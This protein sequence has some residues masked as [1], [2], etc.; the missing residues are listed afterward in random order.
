MDYLV[1]G[2]G[3]IGGTVGAGL[4]RD[5]HDVVFCDADRE[6]VQAMNADGLAIEGPVEQF[7]VP[8]TAITPEDLPDRI[9]AVVLLAVK[10]HHTGSAARMLRGRLS[11]G[12]HVVT[13]QNGLTTDA[14]AHEVG[15]AAVLPAFV[16]FG[17]DRLGPGRILRGN[18]A[19]FR[20]GELDGR[21]SERARRFAAD[22][23][24]VQVTGNILGYEWAKLA[25]GAWLYVTA[26]SGAPIHEVLADPRW[27]PLL[28]AVAGEVLAQAPVRPMA[29]DGFDP[30]R[31][32]SSLARLADFNRASARTHSG[33][34]RDLVA[35]RRV[36]EVAA[37]LA[38]LADP[39]RAPL[40]HVLV[41]AVHAIE[42]GRRRCEPGT[43][44]LLA[45]HERIVRLGRGLNAVAGT[46]AVPDRSA[47]GPLAGC[48]V[49]VK[50]IVAVAGVVTGYGST[51]PAGTAPA[52]ID[53]RVVRRLR[54]AGAEV[55]VLSQCLEYAAGAVHPQVGDTRNPYDR[56]GTSGGSSGGS[57]ALVATGAVALAVGT[58]TGGSIRI[59]AAY[60]GVI[61]LK[62]T[63]GLVPTDGVFPLSPTCDHVGPIAA[64]AASARLLLSVLA[65]LPDK[66]PVGDPAPLP[67]R[68]PVIGVLQA[69]L[70]DPCL[71]T[72][73]RD[74]VSD[75]LSRLREAGWRLV[76]VTASWVGEGER[77][78]AVLG[79]IVCHEAAAVHRDRLRTL[80]DHYGPGTL[81]VL[82][83]GDA[84]SGSRYE[85][86]RAAARRLRERVETSFSG[87]D[88]MVG[89]T[90]PTVAPAHDPPFD[91]AGDPE[92][93]FTGPWNLTGHPAVSI[94]V[95]S[96]GLPV[97]LHLAGRQGQDDA[98]LALAQ[99]V[100]AV[101]DNPR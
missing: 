45:A 73:V 81:A 91:Q 72:E 6:H 26:V 10:A 93:R 8:V 3:A 55:I 75:A 32:P 69:Q 7:T 57:A 79:D 86:A 84:V 65:G 36:T 25:Y 21:I 52:E 50:D 100:L 15:P 43:L 27:Q 63:R 96:P 98:L 12:S 46:V 39:V 19:A 2:A 29:F 67:H 9:D 11:G 58:D 92:G 18:R 41:A 33:V 71:T 5:G 87:L 88:A 83:A 20:V 35:H 48:P 4:V 40:L 13:L 76:P 53:A 64:D 78:G 16:N 66:Q 74:A 62:P 70:D 80:R 14:V 97:G 34:H 42:S 31:L 37:H 17:A 44:A 23:P 56:S 28:L 24:D 60:C 85:A 54:A 47:A 99:Q 49:A 30:A 95:P 61:G 59:P 77:L 94:P 90:V 101:L 51:L 82:A 22:V 68:P 89:P 1:L 38:P